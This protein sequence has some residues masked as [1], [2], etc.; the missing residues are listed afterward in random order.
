MY[1]N[2]KK[3]FFSVIT[4][5]KNDESNISK[6]IESVVNQKFRNFEYIVIDGK[7]KDKTFNEILKYKKKIDFFVSEKDKGIYFAMNKAAKFS[8]GFF[9]VY[10]NSGDTLT[11]NALQIVYNKII[12]NKN[13]D[14]VFGTVRRHYTKDT[15]LKSGY[16]KFKLFYNFDFATAHS[17]GFFLKRSEFKKKGYFDTKYKCSA[18]YDLYYKLIIK[19][20]LKGTYTK[21]S[22]LIGTVQKGGFSS[23]YTFFDHLKEETKIRLNN[24][25]NKLFIM[26]IYFNAIFKFVLKKIFN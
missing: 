18:D 25:Q 9:V 12:K 22:Q 15:I 10:V 6:T 3:P 2:N 23:N 8:K 4:V 24:K 1:I 26:I 20:N 19:S 14:F 7:S 16:N 21:K 13:I 5:V 17:T 11:N